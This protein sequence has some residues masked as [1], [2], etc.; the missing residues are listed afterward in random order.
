[1]D[2]S[3]NAHK[4]SV[5]INRQSHRVVLVV[6][7]NRQTHLHFLESQKDQEIQILNSEVFHI[8]KIEAQTQSSLLLFPKGMTEQVELRHYMLDIFNHSCI[9]V[10][11]VLRISCSCSPR[12]SRRQFCI[13]IYI[14]SLCDQNNS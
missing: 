12:S 5:Y 7:N 2:L 11:S 1:M 4:K 10:N 8:C 6:A 14:V 3:S 13:C 9:A